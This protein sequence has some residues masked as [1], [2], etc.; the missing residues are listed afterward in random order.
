MEAVARP[1]DGPDLKGVLLYLDADYRN[2]VSGGVDL[3]ATNFSYAPEWTIS[4]TPSYE[5]P[6]GGQVLFDTLRL[7]WPWDYRSRYLAGAP[8]VTARMQ[9]GLTVSDAP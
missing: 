3:S 1:I 7:Q 6:L 4:S 8:D 2:Y 5:L 9:P